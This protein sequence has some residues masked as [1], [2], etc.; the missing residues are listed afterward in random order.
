MKDPKMK[1][2]I[3]IYPQPKAEYILLD[4]DHRGWTHMVAIW[5]RALS[6]EEI[7]RLHEPHRFFW[8]PIVVWK[9]TCQKEPF[10]CSLYGKTIH[11][12]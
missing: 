7:Q 3:I 9:K 1:D 6:D 4:K 10:V 12:T 8:K 11:F 5:N 2:S